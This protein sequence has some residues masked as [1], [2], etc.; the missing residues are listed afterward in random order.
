MATGDQPG[1]EVKVVKL[2]NQPP[3]NRQAVDDRHEKFCQEY[4]RDFNAHRAQVAAGYSEKSNA[5]WMLMQR[6]EIVKRVREIVETRKQ[7]YETD[8]ALMLDELRLIAMQSGDLPLDEEGDIDY[9]NLSIEQKRC[10]S[11]METTVTKFGT[12]RK[13]KFHDKLTALLA[14]L[15]LNG[16]GLDLPTPPSENEDDNEKDIVYFVEPKKIK[17]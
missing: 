11:A 2:Q 14:F 9:K 16:L 4:A 8:I 7:N 10:I 6:P 15:K 1:T 12:T 3:M 5:S 17:S 13:I